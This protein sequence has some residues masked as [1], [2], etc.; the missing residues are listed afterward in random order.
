MIK[1]E[2]KGKIGAAVFILLFQALIDYSCFFFKESNYYKQTE[3]CRKDPEPPTESHY[4][5]S[6]TTTVTI[7]G[8]VSGTTTTT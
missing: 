7:S 4:L 1:I 3:F 2:E 6:S 8:T 5:F